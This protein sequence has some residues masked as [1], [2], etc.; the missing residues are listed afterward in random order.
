MWNLYVNIDE[1]KKVRKKGEIIM[2]KVTKRAAE[3][4]NEMRQK[5][6]NTESAML[7]I[8]FG[9]YGWGGPKLQLALDEVKNDDDVVVNS[10][11]IDIV[12]SSNLESYID[13]SIIDYSSNWFNR[14]FTINGGSSSSC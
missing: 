11:G 8:N 1:T 12:Y 14:G 10:E 7:R 5:A 6:E 13:D 9:G 2:V 3:K 4:F